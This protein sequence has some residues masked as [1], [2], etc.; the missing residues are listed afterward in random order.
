VRSFQ[1]LLTS[2][3]PACE[4]A[5]S[6][7]LGADPPPGLEL[8][9]DADRTVRGVATAAVELDGP[10]VRRLVSDH[11]AR[12]GVLET[13]ETLLR[14]VLA[15]VG[16]QWPVLPHGVAVEHLLSHVVTVA[17]GGTTRRTP[18]AG[19]R[20]VL[21]ACVPGELHDLPLVALWAALDVT[22]T[23]TSLLGARTP[24]G[25]LYEATRRQEPALVV[26]FSLMPDWAHAD[27][28][29]D[30]PH[31]PQLLA[32]GPGWDPGRLPGSVEHVDGLLAATQAVTT[33]L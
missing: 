32:A 19:D 25:S 31:G 27:L 20:T 12:H 24:A 6:V 1:D 21:L 23:A 17:L 29:E 4:A 22:R 26:L 2:G 33:L 10:T 11:V 16:V 30:F 28:L 3:M 9:A 13:W 14:P 15:A 8:P 7:L 18:A 5:R